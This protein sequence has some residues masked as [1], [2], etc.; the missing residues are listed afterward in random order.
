MASYSQSDVLPLICSLARQTKRATSPPFTSETTQSQAVEEKESGPSEDS[1][2]TTDD[3]TRHPDEP[4]EP[5]D[6][7]RGMRG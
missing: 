6:T 3:N 2:D 5:P 7:P 1:A 4:T